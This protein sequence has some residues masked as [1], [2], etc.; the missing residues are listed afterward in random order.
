DF[1]TK[2]PK[3]SELVAIPFGEGSRVVGTSVRI[4]SLRIGKNE[5]S[6]QLT[7]KVAANDIIR[8]RMCRLHIPVEAM[9]TRK[10]QR[11]LLA[12]WGTSKHGSPTIGDHMAVSNVALALRQNGAEVDVASYHQV[13]CGD[14]NIVNWMRINPRA[15][16]CVVFV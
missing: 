10:R 16:R 12:W 1:S 3:R 7:K 11:I 5:D 13:E 9:N 15:Y 6:H 14:A 2:L 4:A 8:I